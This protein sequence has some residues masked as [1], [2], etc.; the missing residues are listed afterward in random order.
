MWQPKPSSLRA[1]AQLMRTETKNFK[2]L[3]KKQ[4]RGR[5]TEVR[6]LQTAKNK[7]LSLNPAAKVEEKQF[8]TLNKETATHIEAFGEAEDWFRAY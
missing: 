2:T 4:K 5:N 6:E 8:E 1:Q 3:E 7:A